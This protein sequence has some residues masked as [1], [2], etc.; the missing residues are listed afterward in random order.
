M[1][2]LVVSD[3]HRHAE[4]FEKVYEKVK[5][6]DAVLHL[7]DME[8]QEDLIRS[9]ADCPVYFVKGNC[10]LHTDEPLERELSLGGVKI[11]MAHG[12]K[13]GIN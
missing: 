5:P 9:I 6:V 12:H 3:T 2:I 1:K 4:N 8:G 11:L 7:G 13:Y 10:D